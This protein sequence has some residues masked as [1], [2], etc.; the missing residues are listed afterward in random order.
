VTGRRGA[1]VVV[2][3]VA[4][5]AGGAEA[6]RPA[7]ALQCLKGAKA[8]EKACVERAREACRTGFDAALGECFGSAAGC[9]RDCQRKQSAC[10]AGPSER[11]VACRRDC[12]EET[13]KRL[14]GCPAGSCADEAQVREVKCRQRCAVDTTPALQQCGADFRYCLR[15]CAAN[16]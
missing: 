12:K 2:L 8:E 9:A 15:V 10:Q 5:L 4:L 3:G 16:E 14:A 13:R 6:R 11:Q 7:A 1:A